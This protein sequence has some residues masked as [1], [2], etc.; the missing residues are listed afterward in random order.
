MLK[1]SNVYIKLNYYDN[2]ILDVVSKQHLKRIYKDSL[3]VIK[4]KESFISQLVIFFRVNIFKK[5]PKNREVQNLLNLDIRFLKKFSQIR[6]VA[7]ISNEI[8]DIIIHRTEKRNTKIALTTDS[9]EML[10][11]L[12][13]VDFEKIKKVYFFSDRIDR[14]TDYKKEI[15]KKLVKIQPDSLVELLKFNQPKYGYSIHSFSR[16]E[17]EFIWELENCTALM[18][19]IIEYFIESKNWH[20]GETVSTFFPN[21]GSK[22]EVKAF[23]Y[24]NVTRN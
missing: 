11:S 9:F 3:R 10:L 17:S 7:E 18:D 24:I 23:D 13:N 19:S 20:I 12:S 5:P 4:N 16:E 22:N 1:K 14:Y 21:Q 15:L 8:L 2:F 6:P